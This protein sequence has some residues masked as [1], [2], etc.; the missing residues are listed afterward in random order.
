[1]IDLRTD[2]ITQPTVAMRKAIAEA[3]VGDEQKREDPTVIAL[4]ERSA[5][6]LD[7]EEA[8]FVPTATMA[9]QIALRILT[10]PGD[11]A[12]VGGDA[13]LFLH[14]LG[15]PAVH[16]GLVVKSIETKDGRFSAAQLREAMNPR[17]DL[18]M[19]PTTL[20]CVENTHNGGGGRV[21]PLE[22][23]REVTAEARSL[24]LA[25]HLDG[26]RL[27][28][29]AVAAGL[30][31][32]EFGREF[33]T[34]SICLSKG[35]GCPLGALIAG[36]RERMAKARRLKHL[37][38]GAMR[39]AGIVAAAGLY[40]LDHNVERLADDHAN[41]RRLAGGLVEAGLPV[42]LDQVETN[43]VQVDVGA[44]GLGAD[45]AVARLR[46]EGVLLSFATR[47]D[48][49]RAVTHLDVSAGDVEQAIE[50]IPRALTGAPRPVADAAGAAPTPF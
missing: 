13:H 50:R 20:V 40:A 23:V 11:E 3:V 27:L 24:G 44:L 37:F 33:D 1:M 49:L 22:L 29:A 21:W 4:E 25:T 17:A 32:G 5:E 43:F 18:H 26:A 8:V 28:N 38:G 12:I 9:N 7:H 14:E 31:P 16:S 46:A 41:A 35:L 48:V 6:L 42:D 34:V 2:T 19:A 39:Q 45:D 10:E 36:S 47:K 15:G 30:P